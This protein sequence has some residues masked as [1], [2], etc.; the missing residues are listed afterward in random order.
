MRVYL[1]GASCYLAPSSSRVLPPP[2]PVGASHVRSR[3]FMNASASPSLSLGDFLISLGLLRHALGC[4]RQHFP[5]LSA[6]L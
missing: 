6:N 5:P 1:H 3:A 4:F 2:A